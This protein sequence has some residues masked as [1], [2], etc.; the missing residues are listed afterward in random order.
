M[1]LHL[2]MISTDQVHHNSEAYWQYIQGCAVKERDIICLATYPECVLF[3][4][5][6]LTSTDNMPHQ[7][8]SHSNVP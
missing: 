3:S 1:N 4:L 6:I 7:H 2:D 5:H 8:C